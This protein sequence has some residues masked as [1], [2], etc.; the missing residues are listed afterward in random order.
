MWDSTGNKPLTN[1]PLISPLPIHFP[2]AIIQHKVQTPN[3]HILVLFQMCPSVVLTTRWQCCSIHHPSLTLNYRR[4]WRLT[5][6]QVSC[7]IRV[8][9]GLSESPREEWEG[10]RASTQT[11]E[12]RWS[13]THVIH[14]CD[15]KEI[16]LEVGWAWK[17]C[18]Q[19][20]ENTLNKSHFKIF[21]AFYLEMP[22]LFKSC[23]TFYTVTPESREPVSTS[24]LSSSSSLGY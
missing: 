6:L 12:V 10:P 19:R 24:W 5:W 1:K 18:L 13:R 14:I 21:K 22:A 4:L 2:S 16:W 11:Q 7:E 20:L 3:S 17:L 15:W 23:W 8:R 9:K